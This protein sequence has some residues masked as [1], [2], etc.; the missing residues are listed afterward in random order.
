MENGEKMIQRSD[1]N[2]ES[3]FS[4]KMV[5]Q[6]ITWSFFHLVMKHDLLRNIDKKRNE[7]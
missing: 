4:V 3:N 2:Y 1:R 5:K 7:H 6:S